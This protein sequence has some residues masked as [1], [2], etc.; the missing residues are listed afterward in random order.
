MIYDTAR[1]TA[2]EV[3][4]K[5]QVHLVPPAIIEA[6]AR[7]REYGTAK[8]GDPENWRQVSPEA[9]HDALLRHVLACWEDPYAVD[10]ESGLPHLWHLM[11]N[12]AFL[13]AM[14]EEVKE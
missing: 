6:V 13:C 8:Y 4:G 10:P 12:G 11:C 5:L 2:K 3:R 1:E 14:M 7:V 9:Y